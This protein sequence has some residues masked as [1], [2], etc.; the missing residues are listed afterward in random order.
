MKIKPASRT[1]LMILL[2][3][4]LLPLVYGI[5]VRLAAYRGVE[6]RQLVPE[7]HFH[8]YFTAIQA[9]FAGVG[10]CYL[11]GRFTPKL[12]RLLQHKGFDPGLAAP[13]SLEPFVLVGLLTIITAG[14]FGY[15]LS[16]PDM[17]QFRE[18]SLERAQR[19][20][21]TELYDWALHNAGSND[22]FLV[23]PLLGLYAISSAARKVVV[24]PRVYSNPYVDYEKRR[25][26]AVRM[27]EYLRSGEV[28]SFLALASDY[29]V[30]YVVDAKDAPKCCMLEAI[31]SPNFKVVFERDALTVYELDY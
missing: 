31:D 24:L 11:A 7:F 23:E 17:H 4:T 10:L 20:E 14:G 3:A 29:H 26:D 15:Y 22:V 30:R 2:L 25:R 6:L 9:A 5:I 8:I 13:R 16:S 21:V 1:A 12:A 19:S 27:Y 18:D 28:K